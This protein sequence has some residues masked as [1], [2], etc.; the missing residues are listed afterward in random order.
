MITP[1]IRA[2]VRRLILRDGWK[3]ETVARRFG[4]HHSVVRRAIQDDAGLDGR[5]QRHGSLVDPFK[6]IIVERLGEHPELTSTRLFHE[7][8]ERGYQRVSTVVTTNLHFKEWG[9]LFQN[10][11]AA[12]AIAERLIHKGLLIRIVGPT[13]R[14]PEPSTLT[15]D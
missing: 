15:E 5:E 10:A 1:E 2:Q 6:E 3:I 13:H 14:I 12:S 8:K 11:A 4:V 7:L 9:K